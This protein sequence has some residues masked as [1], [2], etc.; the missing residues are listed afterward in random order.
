LHE[1]LDVLLIEDNE[2]HAF[3]RIHHPNMKFAGQTGSINYMGGLSGGSIAND[4]A[5]EM[6]EK[7]DI[8]LLTF[9]PVDIKKI[10]QAKG[11]I[12]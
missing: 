5:K 11:L 1:V 4:I 6:R 8:L 7:Y 3:L 9:N 2:D 10:F 12:S